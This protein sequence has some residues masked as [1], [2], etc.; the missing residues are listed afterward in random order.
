MMDF[1]PNKKTVFTLRYRTRLRQRNLTTDDALPI[2]GT[3][4]Q[5]NIRLN[6][7]YP[8]NEWIRMK[9]RVELNYVNNN[10]WQRGFLFY[11]DVVIKLPK[12]GL[13]LTARYALFDVNGYDARVYALETDLPYA[14]SFPSFQGKGSRMYA[15]INYDVSRNLEFWLRIGQTF[16]QGVV[17]FSESDLEAINGPTRTDLKVQMRY[18]F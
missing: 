16:R 17:P 5:H 13:S 18:K 3:I 11:H 12:R 1:A 10:S 2:L 8:L 15:I 4:R 14:Y 6:M 9:N 7:V